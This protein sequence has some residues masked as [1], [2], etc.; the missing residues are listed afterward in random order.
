MRSLNRYKQEDLSGGVQC[1]TLPNL[2]GNNQVFH[3][4][5]GE[6]ASKIGAI[7]GRLGSET[8]STLITNKRVLHLCEYVN[9]NGTRTYFALSDDSGGANS[10]VLKSATASFDGAWSVSLADRVLSAD[11][12]TTNFA[13][14]LA[15]FN[16]NDA[17][18][19]WNGSAWSVITN[20]PSSGIYPEV[21]NQRMYV[22]SKTGFLYF[23]DVV[24]ATGDDFTTTTWDNRGI[25]PNE[26]QMA[27][28]LKRHR[29]RLVIF[30]TESIYRYDGTNEPEAV[31]T[32]GTHS[33][34]SV[35]VL[36][37]LFFHHP[38]GIYKMGV[39]EPML[40]SRAV[41]KY[42]D[43]MDSANWEHVASGRDT[44]NV[45]FWI[46]N[47]TISDP[48]EPDWGKTYTDVVLVFNVNDETWT[49][50]SGW[51]ARTWH[52]DESTGTAYFG[53]ANGQIVEIGTGYADV[54]A[55]G[56]INPITFN[57]IFTP[58][59][60][61]FPENEKN[62]GQIFVLGKYE[63]AILAGAS[64]TEME[65]KNRLKNGEASVRAPITCKNLWVGVSEQYLDT[66]PRI[67]GL[68]VD[69][70]SLNDDAR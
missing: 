31:I 51:N 68:V 28:M 49:V 12:Y 32:V 24:N 63:S 17:P 3:C 66:L 55:G 62:V 64:Y 9:N 21:F 29:G 70:I 33:S 20:A 22:L 42:L 35:V 43:G 53:Q 15:F 46:G 26:G 10:D 50:F 45:Y 14:K 65:N 27:K 56:A 41:Q 23:S 25:N 52:Y 59:D 11:G 30:K 39:G 47:V 58:P 18:Q 57:V 40:I 5:N 60:F 7:T 4:E 19:W 8:Q 36:N 44:E 13:N 37:D 2:A 69:R 67:E 54:R 48:L 6:F 1:K 38:T 34:R 61:G 16:G